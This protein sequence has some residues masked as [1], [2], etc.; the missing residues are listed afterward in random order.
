MPADIVIEINEYRSALAYPG[1][2]AIGIVA[3]LLGRVASRITSF[4]RSMPA[5]IDKIRV[6]GPV[7]IALT[8]HV[9][10][11]QGDVFLRKRLISL[12]I[13][14]VTIPKFDGNAPVPVR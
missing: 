5:G 2:N 3:K 9:V 7:G 1:T 13:E 4:H 14:P 11:A 6:V 12:L 10:N 8:G